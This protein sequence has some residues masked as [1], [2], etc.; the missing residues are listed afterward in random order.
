MTTAASGRS[1][2][3]NRNPAGHDNG[4]RGYSGREAIEMFRA[5]RP[6]ITLMDLQMP[7]MSGMDAIIADSR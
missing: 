6:N 7:D 3:A 4:G 2:G 5:T 1:R